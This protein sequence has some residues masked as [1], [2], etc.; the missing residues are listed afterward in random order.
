M[1]NRGAIYPGA[2]SYLEANQSVRSVV[3]RCRSHLAY[4]GQ[5]GE[6]LIAQRLPLGGAMESE[7]MIDSAPGKELIEC[8]LKEMSID[9]F[10][11]NI[12]RN[13]AI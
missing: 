10:S 3:R 13:H 11:P 9:A 8:I 5:M 7:S 1:F 12:S 2:A 4:N 6:D